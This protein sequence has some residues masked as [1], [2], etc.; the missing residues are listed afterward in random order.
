MQLG[1]PKA[2]AMPA[3]GVFGKL[4][5]HGDF[6]RFNVADP[7]VQALIVWLQDAVG[8]LYP[9]NL[10]APKGLRFFYRTQQAA[11]ALV[12][13]MVP[14]VDKVGRKFPLCLYAHVPLA[15]LAKSF[16]GLPEACRAFTD[17]ALR[18]LEAADGADG[19]ALSA[20]ATT[21][22]V[23]AE[24]DVAA[25]AARLEAAA[26][27]EPVEELGR[28]LFG[29]PAEAGL[30]YALTTLESATKQVKGREPGRAQVSLDAPVDHGADAWLWLELCRR[31]LGWK[32]PPPF[33]WTE[34]EAG[35]Q[36]KLLVSLGAP[37]AGLLA[38]VADPAKPQPQL[39]VWPLRTAQ[40][41]AIETVRRTAA[42][43]ARKSLEAKDAQ[44]R[45]L[46]AAAAF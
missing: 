19:P 37:P 30:A 29:D 9:L 39:N 42:G 3:V 24:A 7:V 20:K 23:P 32:A 38:Y 12:G 40:A 8:V 21:L 27:S 18:L 26:G 31:A 34:P 16:A 25:A 14:S 15:P 13:V 11:M 22:S 28:R 2:P 44:V 36:G 5:A 35:T 46:L 4:P 17:A 6:Y 1:R 45:T 33:F 41:Q 10:K 43:V